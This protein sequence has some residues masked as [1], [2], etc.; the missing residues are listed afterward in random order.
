[1]TK[2]DYLTILDIYLTSF[3]A[4]DEVFKI[5]MG[6]QPIA[7]GGDDGLFGKISKLEK[8]LYSHSK[9]KNINEFLSITNSKKYSLIEKTDILY[10][11]K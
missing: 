9:C 4:Y 2:E 5:L 6:D 10:S 1:M 11:Q 7:L 3:V 8:I